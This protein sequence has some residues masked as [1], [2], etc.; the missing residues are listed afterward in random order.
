[1]L[2]GA[3]GA[4][5]SYDLSGESPLIRSSLNLESATLGDQPLRFE[6]DSVVVKDQALR[7]DL[8]LRCG[9]S[10]EVVSIRGAVPFDPSSAAEP[11][12]RK[13][14]GCLEPPG[15]LIGRQRQGSGRQFRSSLDFAGIAD[16]ARGEWLRGGVGRQHHRWVTAELEPD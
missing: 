5:G 7:L 15:G 8:A 9:E 4:K 2:K 12:D 14:W 13:P 11:S 6:R 10:D 16:P 3:L 1:M